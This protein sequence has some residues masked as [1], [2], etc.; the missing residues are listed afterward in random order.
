MI[1]VDAN[2]ENRFYYGKGP[3]PEIG[4]DTA[5]FQV[6]IYKEI[7]AHVGSRNQ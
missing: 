6:A 5:P 3:M 2:Q 4:V 7:D 1:L